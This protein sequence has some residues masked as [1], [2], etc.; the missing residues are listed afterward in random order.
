MFLFLI[1]S[2]KSLR[3][4]RSFSPFYSY[5]AHF[6]RE[7]AI[8][9][10]VLLQAFQ[11]LEQQVVGLIDEYDSHV[12]NRLRWAGG[13]QL[14]KVLCIAVLT[15]QFAHGRVLRGAFLPPAM[16]T[17]VQT[18]QCSPPAVPEDLPSPH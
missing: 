13:A 18:G 16:A 15:S 2:L 3:S 9:G 1:V 8:L 17:R 4:L 6:F 7:A 12:G 11:L 14:Q 5:A 10:K